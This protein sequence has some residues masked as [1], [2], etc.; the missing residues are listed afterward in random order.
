MIGRAAKILVVESK[1][2]LRGLLESRLRDRYTLLAASDGVE[3]ARLYERHGTC[4]AAVVTRLRVPRL[5][6]AP[7]VGWLHHINPRLPVIVVASGR[8]KE[9]EINS[10]LID[11][12]VKVVGTGAARCDLAS[13]LEE[14][15]NAAPER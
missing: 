4:V 6:G 8:E 3:A 7:L 12:A 11:P 9:E 15:V 1:P 2:R 13:L 14:A 5:G 10:L